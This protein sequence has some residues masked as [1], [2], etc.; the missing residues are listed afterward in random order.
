MS[1]RLPRRLV[2]TMT[3][4]AAA[5]CA[6]MLPKLQPPQ[7]AVTGVA[8]GGGNL[9][10]QPIRLTLH[11]TN[12]NDRA[13]AIREIECN[14]ELAGAA[15]AQGTT[16]AAF[17]LPASGETDFTLNLTANLNNVLAALAGGFNHHTVDYRLYGQVRLQ[18]GLVRTIPFDQKGKVRL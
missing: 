11:A 3:L 9:Q 16:E 6:S 4:V 5:G 15:F 10:Q 14:L 2:L 1:P 17:T 18:N 8:I 7:L 13:I 12:P